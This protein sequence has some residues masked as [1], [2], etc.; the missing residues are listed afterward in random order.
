MTFDFID[1]KFRRKP[2]QEPEPGCLTC[3][4]GGWIMSSW[5]AGPHPPYFDVCPDCGNPQ[6]RRSP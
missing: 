4:G 1:R 2:D 3:E 5:Q 6:N